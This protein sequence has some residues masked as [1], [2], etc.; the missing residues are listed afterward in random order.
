MYYQFAKLW[1]CNIPTVTRLPFGPSLL[2]S[3][4]QWE[5][6]KE[7]SSYFSFYC[8]SPVEPLGGRVNADPFAFSCPPCTGAT[9]FH[10]H[11]LCF[12]LSISALF[13]V[14]LNKLYSHENGICLLSF[15]KIQILRIGLVPQAVKKK[16]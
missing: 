1:L 7:T 15:S 12:Q 14:R 10:Y 2:A 16:S 8:F 5:N 9:L 4:K 13:P 6:C 3:H 11:F